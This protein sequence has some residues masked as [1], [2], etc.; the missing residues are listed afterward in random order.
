MNEPSRGRCVVIDVNIFQNLHTINADCD[1]LDLICDCHEGQEKIGD[2]AQ[3]DMLDY[4]EEASAQ[5]EDHGVSDEAIAE[6]T[7]AHEGE[8]LDHYFKDASD[9]KLLVF[10]V[11]NARSVLFTCDK[12]ILIIA[13]HYAVER[14]C[15]KA[16]IEHADR[17]LD[18]G[19]FQD[20]AYATEMMHLPGPHPFFNFGNDKHCPRCD[21]EEQCSTRRDVQP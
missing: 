16:A 21:P 19:I 1:L 17:R 2:R 18:G 8:D 3:L 7:L 6:F 14:A 11:R 20:P 13:G 9:L 5:I 15:F 10:A 12:R 4:C